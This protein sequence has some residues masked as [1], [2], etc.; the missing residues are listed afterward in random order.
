MNK[1]LSVALREFV[2]TV[3]TKTFLFST[4]VMPVLMLGLMFGTEQI[5]E[6]TEN[7][8]QPV[9]KV[10]LL[11]ETEQLLPTVQRGVSEF[12]QRNPTRPLS[13]DAAPEDATVEV[14]RRQVR[15]ARI[16]AYLH[17]PAAAAAPQPYMPLASSASASQPDSRC[18]LGRR[19]VQLETGRV[20]QSIV[21]DALVDLRF[22]TADP[23]IDIARIQVLQTPAGFRDLDV[24]SGQASGGDEL[25]RLLTPFAFMFLLFMGT[26]NISQGLLTSL[27]EEKSTRVVE[28][29]LSALSPQQLMTGK[30]IGMVAVGASVMGIWLIAGMWGARSWQMDYLVTPFRVGYLVLY[31][32]PGFLLIAAFLAAVG[33]ACNTL[34]EAQSM[35]FP[36]TLM[37]IIPLAMWFQIT[38]NPNSGL[39]LIL[40][41]IPPVT[42][43][44]MIL[45]ICADPDLP[46][47]QVGGT[48]VLL[49]LSV[50]A[51][52]WFAGKVFRVGV[53]MYGKPPTLRELWRWVQYA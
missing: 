32:I 16:Y 19:D 8:Q 12:N 30:I 40:S 15:D 9:K 38:Q 53:L 7:E 42:P 36:L 3:K 22:R 39:A 41:F 37:T 44:V 47:W 50:L 5:G 29:L 27:I 10:L 11:D 31:F 6:M 45:R 17:V 52:F 28:V 18:E 33:A 25:A 13:V 48:L 46:L 21:N 34:K 24:R 43:F 49:W 23:P 4:V 1:I 14:L 35:A 2:E 20:L 51:T 26:L